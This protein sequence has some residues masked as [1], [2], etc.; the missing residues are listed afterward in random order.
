[1]FHVSVQTLVVEKYSNMED[2][3]AATLNYQGVSLAVLIADHLQKT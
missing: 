3:L 1:M 2:W